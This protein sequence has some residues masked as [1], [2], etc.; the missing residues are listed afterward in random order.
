MNDTLPDGWTRAT[1]KDVTEPVP[2]IKPDS[3]PDRMFG[4]VDISS[5]DN[6]SF[7]ITGVKKVLGKNAP[8][9]ARRP[10]KPFDTLFSNVRTYLRNVALVPEGS[11]AEVCS[12]GFTVLRPNAAVDPKYLF[13]Y[14]LTD[15]FLAR[16]TPRQTGTHYPATSDRVVR[17]ESLPLAPLAEQRRIV[18]K[19]ERVLEKVDGC[20]ERLIRIPLI[21]ERFRQSIR[22]AACS[23]N[24]TVDWRAEHHTNE[25]ATTIVDV[26]RERRESETET[27]AK[28]KK[29]QQLF[30]KSESNDSSDLPD[31]WGY[32]FL[33]KLSSSFNYGTSTK[34][35]P[36]GEVPVLRMGN[37]QGGR[38]DWG[39]LVYTSNV[40]EIEK[41]TLEPKT[42][43]FNRTNSPELVGKTAIYRGERPA[44]FAGYLIRINHLPELD[45]EYLNICLNTDY[46]KAFCLRQKT[47]GVS[48][49]NI[50]AQKLGT[51]EVPFCPLPEQQEIVRRV[52]ALFALADQVEDRYMNARAFI[53]KVTPSILE[54]AF[55][56]TL[57]PTEAELAAK[58]GR[59][60][61]PA[62]VLLERIRQQ[63]E[64]EKL[65]GQTRTRK[66]SKNATA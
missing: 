32:V 20:Q 66:R 24:L 57:T 62:E 39:N 61:E 16:V 5:I 1:I 58:E 59:D 11:S 43:L 48:Q 19:L 49:S 6:R 4:Y 28:K 8:S 56:G 18:A 23:S 25:T 41:Y 65:A 64:E 3:E 14:V 7:T 36:S 40:D 17:S 44:V 54:R 27:V 55:R 26:I 42:V 2:N 38:I 60:F 50:N 29:L 30:A 9:R 47:D 35:Q 33:S 53:E 21:L 63:R 15:D 52:D 22:S 12:T 13:R 10:V 45:P 51:F 34:S 31:S 46:A 37:I